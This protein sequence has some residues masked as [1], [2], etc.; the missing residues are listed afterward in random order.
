M[1]IKPRSV[2]TL[3]Y[4]L[5]AVRQVKAGDSIASVSK[6]LGVPNQTLFTWVKLEREGS[7]T[8]P[9]SKAVSVEQMEIARLR[10]ENSRL[11]MER[12]ILK[13]TTAYFA[14]ETL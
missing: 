5:E 7:L 2:Y 13:K 6:I 4:K 8:G 1:S 10:A 12:D 11:K 14:K 9:G 3:E